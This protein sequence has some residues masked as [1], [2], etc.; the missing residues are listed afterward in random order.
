[1]TLLT[2]VEAIINFEAVDIS[3]ILGLM[4]SGYILS[5]TKPE[6]FG[7][8]SMEFTSGTCSV[9]ISGL[10][11]GFGSRLGSGC[12]SGNLILYMIIKINKVF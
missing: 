5:I 1:M 4:S 3:Y 10:L 6:V 9:V 2:S 8:P 7:G 11:V 12:T